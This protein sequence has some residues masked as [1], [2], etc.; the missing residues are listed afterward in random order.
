MCPKNVTAKLVELSK[1]SDT[2][3]ESTGGGSARTAN[4]HTPLSKFM[5][6]FFPRASEALEKATVER[7]AMREAL[8]I[9]SYGAS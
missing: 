8:T 7:D 5:K 1:S 3:T 6:V 4:I 2:T 9:K